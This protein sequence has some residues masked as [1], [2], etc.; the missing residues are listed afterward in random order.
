MHYIHFD[1]NIM[2]GKHHVSHNECIL[3][4]GLHDVLQQAANDRLAHVYRFKKNKMS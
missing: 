4:Y 2:N 3:Q 1:A